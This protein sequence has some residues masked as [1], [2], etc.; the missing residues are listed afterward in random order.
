MPAQRGSHVSAAAADGLAI[1]PVPLWDRYERAALKCCAA[2]AGVGRGIV[3]CENCW[4]TGTVSTRVSPFGACTSMLELEVAPQWMSASSP[5]WC[6]CRLNVEGA[7][8]PENAFSHIPTETNQLGVIVN[9]VSCFFSF[10]SIAV[11]G[12]PP[13]LRVCAPPMSEPEVIAVFASVPVQPGG[14]GVPFYIGEARCKN[15]WGLVSLMPRSPPCHSPTH[16]R[17]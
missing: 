16:A 9:V 15:C 10:R 14:A 6:F 11:L 12:F 13:P 7:V 3:R 17:S 4:G 2:G 8:K 1:T 5:V